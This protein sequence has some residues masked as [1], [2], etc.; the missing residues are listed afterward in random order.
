MV[1][2][3]RVRP[4]RFDGDDA[5]AVFFDQS[6]GDRRSAPVE[7]GGA[8]AGLADQHHTGVSVAVEQ[9]AER[10]AV[11]RRQRLGVAAQQV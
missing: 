11:Q 4:V 6:A 9:R 7:L 10:G 3:R 5:E 8:V 1:D 2:L